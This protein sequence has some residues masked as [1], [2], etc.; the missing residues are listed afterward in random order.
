[1][2]LKILELQHKYPNY[3]TIAAGDYNVCM[4]PNDSL[5]RLVSNSEKCL[6]ETKENNNKITNLVDAYRLKNKDGGFTWNRG[7]CYSRLD[8][9]FISAPL[10]QF[11]VKANHDW[12][13]EN[14]DLAA[15]LIT[16][17]ENNNITRGPGITKINT[18][19]LDDPK[20]VKQIENEIN[21]MMN[22]ADNSWNPHKK[23]ELIIKKSSNKISILPNSS[24]TKKK[25]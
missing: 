7:T 22:Q 20:L 12:T 25:N 18:A 1:M 17:K 23:L 10:S 2:Y 14:S 13:F 4:K 3:L 15:V 16:L 8:Y 9:I 5:K 24:R 21:I 11:V 19:V 6:L